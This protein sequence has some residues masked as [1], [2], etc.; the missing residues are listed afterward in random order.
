MKKNTIIGLIIFGAYLGLASTRIAV[1]E[2][3]TTRVQNLTLTQ[4]IDILLKKYDDLA[5]AK[6]DLEQQLNQAQA[7]VERYKNLAAANRLPLPLLG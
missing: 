5:A 2:D 1:A 7:E 3:T 6:K 4:K